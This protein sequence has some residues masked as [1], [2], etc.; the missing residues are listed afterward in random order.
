VGAHFTT[1]LWQA[2]RGGHIG[3]VALGDFTMRVASL[4]N[5]ANSGPPDRTRLQDLNDS[6]GASN[7]GSVDHHG[8]E[9]L[10]R[11]LEP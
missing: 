10:L 1:G 8:E 11:R 2:L 6:E 4:S 7:W 3:E 5:S 9:A